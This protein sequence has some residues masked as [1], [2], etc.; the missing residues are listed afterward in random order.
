M[1]CL[2]KIKCITAFLLAT[3]CLG[4]TS[5]DPIPLDLSDYDDIHLRDYS[6]CDSCETYYTCKWLEETYNNTYDCC[7]NGDCAEQNGP[8]GAWCCDDAYA[9][10]QSLTCEVME[11]NYKDDLDKHLKELQDFVD[12]MNSDNYIHD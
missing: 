11:T 1:N 7:E 3:L 9:L 12:F 6:N 4:D 8:L 5:P 2:T 10:D